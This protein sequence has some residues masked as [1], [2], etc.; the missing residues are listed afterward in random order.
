MSAPRLDGN[1]QPFYSPPAR[2]SV[3]TASLPSWKSE[4]TERCAARIKEDRRRLLSAARER[5]IS[6]RDV[7]NQIVVDE[8]SGRAGWLAHQPA[9]VVP[10]GSGG[11]RGAS[12]GAGDSAMSPRG[13]T[14][15]SAR[16]PSGDDEGDAGLTDDERLALLLYLE[17]T[18]YR[19]MQDQGSWRRTSFTRI[20]LVMSV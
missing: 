16:E 9:S 3:K 2:K 13:A 11:S 5:S 14:A 4:L 12:G 15:G 8:E 17:D 6:V 1:G 18:L 10:G 19:D 7:L 20:R